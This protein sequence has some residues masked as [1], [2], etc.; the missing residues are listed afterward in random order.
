[1]VV[2]AGV[3]NQLRQVE[4]GVLVAAVQVA[5]I[6]DL[7]RSQELQIEVAVAVEETIQGQEQAEVLALSL[8]PIQ[9]HSQYLQLLD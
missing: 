8:L 5:L 2:E 7:R 6:W 9:T 3:T 1:V 4:A